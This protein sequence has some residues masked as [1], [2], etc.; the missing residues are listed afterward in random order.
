MTFCL[1]SISHVRFEFW[2]FFQNRKNLELTPDQNDDPVTRWPKRE[3]WPKWPIDPVT[4]WPSSMSDLNWLAASRPS[5]TTHPLVTHFSVNTW[6]AAAKLGR[7]WTH[8]LTLLLT[9]SDGGADVQNWLVLHTIIRLF[10]LKIANFSS[11][12]VLWILWTKP[13]MAL[14]HGAVNKRCV[15][16]ICRQDLIRMLKYIK[17]EGWLRK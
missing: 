4:Q 8:L 10:T 5:Y 17:I 14:F 16:V 12:H 11:V 1:F 15:T 13:L 6:L 2:A 3:R 9:R 7:F